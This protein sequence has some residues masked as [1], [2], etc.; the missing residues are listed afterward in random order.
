MNTFSGDVPVVGIKGTETLRPNVKGQV[1]K[2]KYP[3]LGVSVC[4]LYF[5]EESFIFLAKTFSIDGNV[6]LERG[7][8]L[9][10]SKRKLM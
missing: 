7:D 9:G 5:R 6:N 1:T 3:K 8:F 2:Q 10:S 4:M